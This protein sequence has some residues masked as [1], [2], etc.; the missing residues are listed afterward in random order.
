MAYVNK[1]KANKAT[2]IPDVGEHDSLLSCWTNLNTHRKGMKANRRTES[3]R[4]EKEDNERKRQW[5]DEGKQ[6]GTYAV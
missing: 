2:T 1:V 6:N 3:D 4:Q 5:G